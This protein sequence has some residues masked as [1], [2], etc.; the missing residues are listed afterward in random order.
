MDQRHE[1]AVGSVLPSLGR[2]VALRKIVD[3]VYWVT[4]VEHGGYAFHISVVEDFLSPSAQGYGVLD[5]DIWLC[6][7]EDCAWSLVALEHPE[8]EGNAARRG[9]ALEMAKQEY[10]GYVDE[11]GLT[12]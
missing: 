3:G 8:W 10:P 5:T 7:E 1:L 12:V 6:Y 4:T 11:R 2:I 9:V